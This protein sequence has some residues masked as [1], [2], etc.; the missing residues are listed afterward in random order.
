MRGADFNASDEFKT[1][2]IGKRFCFCYRGKV[3]CMCI[4][5]NFRSTAW[6]GAV[7]LFMSL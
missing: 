1:E 4:S 6:A 3:I 7:L 5:T 2:F